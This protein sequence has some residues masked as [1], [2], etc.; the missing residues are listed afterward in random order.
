[1]QAECG[2]DPGLFQ[3]PI[4]D[5]RVRAVG[6]LLR[7]LER[8]LHRARSR[9]AGQPTR[10][11]EP[12]GD[13]PIVATGVHAAGV[14][15]PVGN[16]VRFFERQR[17][18]IGAQQHASSTV[19]GEPYYAGLPHLSAYAIAEL[20]EPPGDELAGP[21]LLKPQ[22]RI[23]MEISPGGDQCRAVDGGKVHARLT[24][25]SWDTSD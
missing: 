16:V 23:G 11:L 4:G 25:W 22:F 12:D 19:A 6:N 7:G 13:V 21:G 8:E 10:D 9:E 14:L 15:R 1:M 5:H 2:V 3:H 18:H 20:L 17:V 24:P